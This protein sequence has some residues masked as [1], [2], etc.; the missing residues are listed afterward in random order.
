MELWQLQPAQPPAADSSDAGSSRLDN[1]TELASG[2]EL[3][4]FDGSL[5]LGH[6]LGRAL[7]GTVNTIISVSAGRLATASAWHRAGAQSGA[8]AVVGSLDHLYSS[9]SAFRDSPICTP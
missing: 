1:G 5:G 2:V 8:S 7:S 6:S 9:G 4:A 3:G